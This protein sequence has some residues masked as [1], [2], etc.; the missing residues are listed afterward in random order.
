MC[1]HQWSDYSD[2]SVPF[3][4]HGVLPN[5]FV[6]DFH[7]IHVFLNTESLDR[8]ERTR[9]LHQNP[10]ELIKHRYEG[11]GTRNRLLELLGSAKKN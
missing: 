5:Y 3:G 4:L 9:S 10:K 2:I 8:Y 11:Y 6:V 1:P 7:P